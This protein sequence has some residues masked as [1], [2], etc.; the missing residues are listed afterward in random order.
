MHIWLKKAGE[1]LKKK[2]LVTN[3]FPIAQKNYFIRNY[4][5]AWRALYDKNI[6]LEN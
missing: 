1:K 2:H 5:K 4:F 3:L 6:Y